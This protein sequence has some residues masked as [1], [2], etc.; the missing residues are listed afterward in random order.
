MAAKPGIWC[1]EGKWFPAVTDVHSVQVILKALQDAKRIRLAFHHL[2][3][4][5][6]LDHQLQQW[7]KHSSYKIG[8]LAL[9]GE[10]GTVFVDGKPVTMEKMAESAA[11]ALTGKHLHFGSCEVMPAGEKQRQQL[12]RSLGARSISGFTKE[13]EWFESLAFELL[14]FDALTYYDG[15]PRTEAYLKDAA[16]SLW[17]RTGFVLTRKKVQ[18]RRP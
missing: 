10:P 17:K 16:G 11:G 15:D 2:N 5:A 18:Q 14:L 6:D 13:V 8:Y 9:H 3:T 7:K 1:M 12:R 4:P